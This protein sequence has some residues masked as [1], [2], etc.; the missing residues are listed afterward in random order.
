MAA[1]V[2]VSPP[3]A[4]TRTNT[5]VTKACA[6]TTQMQAD[7]RLYR[8]RFFEGRCPAAHNTD[9][10]QSLN[11]G[12]YVKQSL[13]VLTVLAATACIRCASSAGLWMMSGMTDEALPFLLLV[14]REHG[15]TLQQSNGC[16]SV[17]ALIPTFSFVQGMVRQTPNKSCSNTAAPAIEVAVLKD[18]IEHVGH[19]V[20]R[21]DLKPLPRNVSMV[22]DA[23]MSLNMLASRTTPSSESLLTRADL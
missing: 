11:T 6:E 20:Y 2:S 21:P 4:T 13:L 5:S 19:C 17:H 8:K 23:H 9:F 7:L 10:G 16:C 14:W 22:A 18:N 15:L 12:F 3:S 1:R